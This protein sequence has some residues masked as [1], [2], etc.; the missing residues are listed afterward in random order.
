MGQV[1]LA[2]NL[3]RKLFDSKTEAKAWEVAEKRRIKKPSSTIPTVSCHEWATL[4]LDHATK[5]RPKV[6]SEKRAIL[7]RFLAHISPETPVS[8]VSKGL[9]LEYLQKQFTERSGYAANRERKNLVAAWSFGIKFIEGFPSVDPFSQV[10]KF[11]EEKKGRYVPPAEDFWK[12]YA[13]AQGQDK[14]MLL[15]FVCTAAR[16]GEVYRL[17]WEDIDF[18]NGRIRLWTRKRRGGDLEADWLHMV[19]ELREALLKHQKT[20][21]P[22]WVFTQS[23]GRHKGKPYTENRGFPQELCRDVGVDPFGLHSIR[24][25]TATV[26]AKL[27][28]PM[29]EIQAVLRH[30][31]LATTERYIQSLQSTTSAL[32]ALRGDFLEKAQRDTQHEKKVKP[33]V[34]ASGFI[35]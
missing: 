4:Y 17:R 27:G 19:D 18:L 13:Q 5:F 11:P 10:D 7:R 9:A 16:R 29:V 22:E 3:R 30:K 2:G 26:L 8:D 34:A 14:V 1:S 25:L 28:K 23:V 15:T 35:K 12:V 32:E 6:Y 24:H 20:A 31:N 21:S 33:E